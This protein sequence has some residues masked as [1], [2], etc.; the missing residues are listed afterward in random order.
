LAS[1]RNGTNLSRRTRTLIQVGVVYAA[2]C[3]VSL[4]SRVVDPAIL[5][6]IAGGIAWPLY[7]AST[8]GG[9][10]T[11]GLTTKRLLP[12]IVWGLLGGAAVAVVGVAIAQSRDV[13]TVVAADFIWGVP[14]W[15]LLMS[16]FQ[17]LFFRGYMQSQL[18]ETLGA[19]QGLLLA[20]LAYTVW[21][22]MPVFGDRATTS[23]PV[24]TLAGAG[25]TLFAGLVF[26]F[27]FLRTKNI[28]APWLAHGI[29]GVTLVAI[30]VMRFGSY[31]Q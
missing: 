13:Q 24:T 30:G 12:A 8:G 16:P 3:G 21:H 5:A 23:L 7:W 20:S 31:I 2:F 25:A 4:L 19:W 10:R 6:V 27:V 15:F 11:L 22:V 14:V 26:G 29:A 1:R 9:W 17:E 28:V 18:V